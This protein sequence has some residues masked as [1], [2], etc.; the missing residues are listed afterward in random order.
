MRRAVR[1]VLNADAVDDA[2][3]VLVLVSPL[4]RAEKDVDGFELGC[5]E[6]ASDDVHRQGRAWFPEFCDL[7]DAGRSRLDD[8]L[9]WGRVAEHPDHH[10]RSRRPGSGVPNERSTNFARYRFIDCFED[11]ADFNQ[12]RCADLDSDPGHREQDVGERV[13]AEHFGDLAFE[14]VTLRVETSQRVGLLG[15]HPPV[16]G[17]AGQ[18]EDLLVERVEDR[19]GQRCSGAR[20][21]VFAEKFL[22][23]GPAG[24]AD[25]VRCRI[26]PEQ[27]SKSGLGGEFRADHRLQRRMDR[28]QRVAHP[29]DQTVDVGAEVLVVA[30]E[31]GEFGDKLVVLWVDPP[32]LLAERPSDVAQYLGVTLIGFR[33]AGKQLC[34][35]VCDEAWHIRDAGPMGRGSGDHEPGVRADLIDRQHPAGVACERREPR[36]QRVERPLIVTYLLFRDRCF[37]RAQTDFD[38]SG[39]TGNQCA[40]RA[41]STPC[42]WSGATSLEGSKPRSR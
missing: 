5:G 42:G 4:Q 26:L 33:L 1:D 3:R 35:P 15:N 17:G 23:T 39:I 32:E 19:C 11:V 37:D 40:R 30:A 9:V 31:H 36:E 25:R 41:K 27:R 13:A 29:V 21:V 10:L 22:D 34:G 2:A 20:L 8:D 18:D 14:L 16:R 6:R 38:A 24:S 28:T 12:D 7:D